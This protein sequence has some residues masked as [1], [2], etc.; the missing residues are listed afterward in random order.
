MRKGDLVIPTARVVVRVESSRIPAKDQTCQGAMSQHLAIRRIECET[1]ILPA[2]DLSQRYEPTTALASC[3]R[4]RLT[5]CRATQVESLH[6]AC[7]SSGSRGEIL[8]G[9]A[10]AWICYLDFK[11]RALNCPLAGRTRLPG[12]RAL[13]ILFLVSTDKM[14]AET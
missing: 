8:I 4:A 5:Y 6:C 10:T 13:W 14:K 3:S 7:F 11:N 12:V 9:T 1:Q 2:A